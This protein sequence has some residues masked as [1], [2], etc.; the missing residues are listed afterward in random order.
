VHSL[1]KIIGG[2]IPDMPLAPMI[3]LVYRVKLAISDTITYCDSVISTGVMEF[4]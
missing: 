2:N 3:I 1:N 4:E